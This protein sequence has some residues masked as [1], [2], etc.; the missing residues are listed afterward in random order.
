MK[1][2]HALPAVALALTMLAVPCACAQTQ[3]P[4]LW[5]HR[6]AMKSQDGQVE[7]A[8]ALMRQQMEAMPPEQR[9]K[10]EEM[11][12]SRGVKMGPQGTTAKVC[13]S[14]E[15]AAKGAE[16]PMSGDCSRQDL[17]RSGNTMKYRFECSKPQP[18]T[19]EGEVTFVSD[20]AYNG[21]AT[22]T[23]QLNG[24]PRQMSMEMSGKWLSADCGDIKP[25]TMPAK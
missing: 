14:K 22:V 2:I 5:E 25:M 23:S 20:K 4:G 6:F 13:L 16:P 15:Q 24:Q 8:M 9:Q 3:A 12:A 19:G 11:M 18:M 21:K 7:A 17:T 10:L 1:S